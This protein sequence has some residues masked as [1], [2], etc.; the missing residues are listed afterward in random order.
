MCLSTAGRTSHT[1]GTTLDCTLNVHIL[2]QNHASSVLLGVA[3]DEL[4]AQPRTRKKRMI[5]PHDGLC[6]GCILFRFTVVRF[7]LLHPCGNFSP[8]PPRTNLC[9]CAPWERSYRASSLS[10]LIPRVHVSFS[11]PHA[12]AWSRF[13]M[14]V[15]CCGHDHPASS[16]TSSVSC[17]A[18]KEG[19][20]FAVCSAL[21]THS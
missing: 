9:P 15:D 19:A 8:M 17:T 1:S 2:K 18:M 12:D 14:D 21:L 5:R 6:A 16:S 11:P 10:I 20:R 4:R 3:T 7:T 13:Q